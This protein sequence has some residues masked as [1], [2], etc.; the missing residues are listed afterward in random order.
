WSRV[1]RAVSDGIESM[2]D[3]DFSISIGNVSDPD[4]SRLAAAY[5]ILGELL[6]RERLDLYQR[7]L[8]LDTVIQTTP[9]AT[10]LTNSA[11]Q[12]VFSNI[13]ARQL[14]GSGKKLEGLTLDSLLD[15]APA[16]LREALSSE[17]DR[18]F[19]MDV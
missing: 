3:R 17:E 14:F 5:N 6:R 9:L 4:L 10:L 19:T 2:R 16:A 1:L 11:G 8:L 12:I 13:S 15:T 18:L 7:E